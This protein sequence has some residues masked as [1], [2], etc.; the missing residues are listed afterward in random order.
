MCSRVDK[1]YIFIHAIYHISP[2]PIFAYFGYVFLEAF[3][4]NLQQQ[5][6]LLQFYLG[7]ATIFRKM[8]G[9]FI[10]S[11]VKF[12]RSNWHAVDL[13]HEMC[14]LKRDFP[15]IKVLVMRW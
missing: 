1:E 14:P 12:I 7:Q 13:S 11:A 3:E 8:T 10:R 4:N 15:F 5:S 9:L 6:F 2:C